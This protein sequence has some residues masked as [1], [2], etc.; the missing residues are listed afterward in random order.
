M[1]LIIF[2]TIGLVFHT[3]ILGVKNGHFHLPTED[4]NRPEIRGNILS[5]QLSFGK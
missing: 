5:A 4:G 1:L 2:T 3:T